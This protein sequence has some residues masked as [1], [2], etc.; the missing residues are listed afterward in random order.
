MPRSGGEAC[1]SAVRHELGVS[2]Q[3]LRPDVLR[4]EDDH[5]IK[6]VYLGL[7]DEQLLGAGDTK[8]GVW[9][10]VEEASPHSPRATLQI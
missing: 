10:H 5:V 4:L 1:A 2:S 3:R 7:K 9:G 6:R 8:N